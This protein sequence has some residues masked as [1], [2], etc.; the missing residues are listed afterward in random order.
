MRL[1]PNQAL[2]LRDLGSSN[3]TLLNGQGLTPLQDYPL[4]S[5]DSLTLG[6][7]TRLTL[8]LR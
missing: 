5:G 6:H 7:W 4:Q 2:S 1:Q 8:T 3:G